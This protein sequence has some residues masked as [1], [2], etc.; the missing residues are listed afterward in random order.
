MTAGATESRHPPGAVLSLR[1]RRVTRHVIGFLVV[2]ALASAVVGFWWWRS[3]RAP[4]V[5]PGWIAHTATLAGDGSPGHRNGRS[6][7]ARF[8]DPFGVA[9]AADGTVFVADAGEAQQ[10][11]RITPDGSVTTL[12]GSVEGY[13]DGPAA[14]ARFNTPSGLAL[15]PA[16]DLFLADTGNN[17]IRRIAPDGRVT[18]VAG[19]G[20]AGFVDAVGTDARFNG[21]VGVAV[22]DAGRVLVADTY[23][24]RIRAVSNGGVVTTLAGSGVPGFLDGPSEAAQFDAP[25]GVAVDAT[26]AVYVA[27]TGNGAVRRIGPSGVVTTIAPTPDGGLRRPIGIAADSNGTIYVTDDRGRVVEIVP[28]VSARILAGSRAGYADGADG[29]MRGLAGLALGERG[30]LVISDPRNAMVRIV[31]APARFPLVP[32]AAPR[33]APPLT[34]SQL[35]P[36]PLWWPFVPMEGPF[37]ITGTPGEPRGADGSERF[38]AGLDVHAP[39]G[40]VVRA[41]RAGIVTAPVSTGEFGSINESL[42][43]GPLTY[44]H[45]RVGRERGGE[46]FA[47]PR[48]AVTFDATGRAGY[49]RIRRGAR[50]EPGDP[51]GTVNAFNHVHLNAGW[52]GEELNP[53]HLRLVQFTDTVPPTIAPGGVRVFRE[54][55]TPFSARVRRRLVLDG[56][57]RVVV[58]AYDQVDGNLPRRRL[59]LYRLG[60][61]VL[62]ADGTPVAGY[63]SP[64]ETLRFDRHSDSSDAAR[65]VYASGSRISVYS[66]RST[67]FYYVVTNTFRDGE[68]AEGRWDTSALAPG[69]YVLRILAADLAGNEAVRNRDLPITIVSATASP[70]AGAPEVR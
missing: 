41:A 67:R 65:L 17:A 60:F 4:A 25:S 53:L 61:Q 9:W 14:A 57:V 20:P 23:N 26:G 58:D 16:G 1:S 33:A 24:D 7:E 68:A 70:A 32:L 39:E 29:L 11:R 28:D 15:G 43:I 64:H 56:P 45:L 46:S 35:G 13:V 69:D 48:F 42:R 12:A 8:S 10:I 6:G 47:D 2:V 49:V 54:D 27:D 66:R 63:E 50:F 62:H 44:V 55:G 40:T 22:D 18:T 21:P 34:A 38:H 51:I 37:E 19:G 3:E 31:A 59:G 36:L 5:E 52:P 30:R